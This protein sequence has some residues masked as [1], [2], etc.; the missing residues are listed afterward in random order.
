MESLLALYLVGIG[1]VEG[2]LDLG[3]MADIVL[4]PSDANPSWWD[5]NDDTDDAANDGACDGVESVVAWMSAGLALI[6]DEADPMWKGG[7]MN[8]VKDVL[9]KVAMYA[10]PAIAQ[11]E[12]R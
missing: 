4:L 12:E 8:F 10:V 2:R 7:K 5:D 1:G 6:R 9:N 11:E 3:D